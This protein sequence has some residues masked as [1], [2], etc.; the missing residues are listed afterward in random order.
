MKCPSPGMY[1]ALSL[2][3]D[4]LTITHFRLPELGFF[5][6]RTT[7]FRTTP[8]ICGFPS[9][10]G[11]LNKASCS[12]RNLNVG[13]TCISQSETLRVAVCSGI[14]CLVKLIPFFIKSKSF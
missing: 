7:V 12:L 2:P 4:N 14:I 5:G 8:F 9:K 10:S 11:F 6:L 13:L 1:A 3:F